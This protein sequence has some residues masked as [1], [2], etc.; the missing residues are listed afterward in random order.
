VSQLAAFTKLHGANRPGSFSQNDEERVILSYFG[1]HVGCFIDCGAH[2]GVSCSNTFALSRRSWGGV[3]IE[4]DPEAVTALRLT[5]AGNDSIAIIAAAVTAIDG[6]VDFYTSH[7]G[8]VSTTSPHHARVWASATR[9]ERISVP[10]VSPDTLLKMYPGTF[11]MLSVDVEGQSA[12]TLELFNLTDM[13]TELVVAE[14]DGRQRR[15][16]E[17]CHRHGLVKHLL[18][19]SENVIYAR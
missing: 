19:N 4:P 14:H 9:F 2:D 6:S 18:T 13:G 5:H 3:C 10:S 17:H 1:D 11:E 12:E 7:G 16:M 15:V 8:G